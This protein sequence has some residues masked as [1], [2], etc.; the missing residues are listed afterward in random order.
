MKSIMNISM[1]ISGTGTQ[2]AGNGD[3][4]TD[5]RKQRGYSEDTADRRL[6]Y[7]YFLSLSGY[8][9]ESFWGCTGE[10]SFLGLALTLSLTFTHFHQLFT[11]L[12]PVLTLSRRPGDYFF[13]PF[14]LPPIVTGSLCEVF[15]KKDFVTGIQSFIHFQRNR[16]NV[17]PRSRIRNDCP[18]ALPVLVSRPELLT[19]QRG[20]TSICRAIL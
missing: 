16:K 10:S 13:N 1:F 14:T 7:I 6:R 2:I 15:L 12:L 4:E 9:G 3:L 11:T 18:S 19:Q 20:C 8:S 17:W 5:D